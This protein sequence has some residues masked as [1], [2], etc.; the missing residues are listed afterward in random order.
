MLCQLESTRKVDVLRSFVSITIL[1][2]RLT[3]VW[4]HSMPL[5]SIYCL[6]VAQDLIPSQSDGMDMFREGYCKASNKL[7]RAALADIQSERL[8]ALGPHHCWIA[9]YLLDLGGI[10]KTLIED[11]VQWSKNASPLLN[12]HL[13]PVLTLSDGSHVNVM[14]DH[15]LRP[16]LPQFPRRQ[17]I[18][19]EFPAS[20]LDFN[21]DCC[22]EEIWWFPRRRENH[23][24]SEQAREETKDM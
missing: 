9:I 13:P 4:S 14:E 12:S 20:L 22:Q 16:C 5:D 3:S 2:V 7:L 21:T 19:Q 11:L 18:H 6:N 24:V 15:V 10:V 8:L 23:D 17:G 1:W